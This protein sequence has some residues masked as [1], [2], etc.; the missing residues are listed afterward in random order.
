MAVLNLTE[1]LTTH[2]GK[3]GTKINCC[4][5]L[6]FLGHFVQTIFYSCVQVE[7]LHLVIVGSNIYHDEVFPPRWLMICYYFILF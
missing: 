6:S 4:L 7:S 3:S 1:V 2:F 5:A